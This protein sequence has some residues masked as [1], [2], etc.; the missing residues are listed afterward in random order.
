MSE[1]DV[2]ES[3]APNPGPRDP[4][5]PLVLGLLL[6]VL[7][8]AAL[9]ERLGI[10]EAEVLGRVLAD[11]VSS[12]DDR[13][14]RTWSFLVGTMERPS[15]L[16]GLISA[17][18]AL[19]LLFW[20]ARGLG[21]GGRAVA[22]LGMTA[23]A[24]FWSGA[25]VI[26]GGGWALALGAAL[27]ALLRAANWHP[28][29]TA[30]GGGLGAGILPFLLPGEGA[31]VE[32]LHHFVPALPPELVA[33]NLTLGLFA[34]A[35]AAIFLLGGRRSAL[36]P[37]VLALALGPALVAA[38]CEL[39]TGALRPALTAV[40]P[41]FGLALGFAYSG[42]SSR[43]GPMLALVA[44]LA[45]ACGA[46]AVEPRLPRAEADRARLDQAAAR[47]PESGWLV[48]AGPRAPVLRYYERVGHRTAGRSI[49]VRGTAE[50]DAVVARALLDQP[51]VILLVDADP[52]I[53]R[54]LEGRYRRIE[55]PELAAGL[56]LLSFERR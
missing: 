30:L 39:E 11:E 38:V 43:R 28:V 51:P 45:V 44:L 36:A 53:E 34:A 8:L 22:L 50:A 40:L 4:T 14:Q 24:P 12:P 49:L 41:A 31:R 23:A 33:P 21:R 19:V 47:L 10:G 32:Q 5:A 35:L 6:L 25:L 42:A 46:A 37:T 20:S 16:L 26:G 27:V 52:A 13:I 17:G 2:Q 56:V 1:T 55:S 18:L 9:S 3:P 48:L 29:W 54:G 7:G 15:R